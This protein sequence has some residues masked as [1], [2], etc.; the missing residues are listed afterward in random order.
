MRALI[1]LCL[2]LFLTSCV[3]YVPQT[4]LVTV[5]QY[6]PI[7][8]DLT[9]PCIT[10]L[11]SPETVRDALLLLVDTQSQLDDC[12]RRMTAIRGLSESPSNP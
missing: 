11:E 2:T 9:I 3:R 10:P 1:A 5:T 4:E 6:V 8:P 12:N 7:P